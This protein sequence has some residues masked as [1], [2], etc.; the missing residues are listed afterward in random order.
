MVHVHSSWGPQRTFNS[1]LSRASG[2]EI[3][4]FRFYRVHGEWSDLSPT[5]SD[6]DTRQGR[7]VT[8]ETVPL[9]GPKEAAPEEPDGVGGTVLVRLRRCVSP[10]RRH[11]SGTRHWGERHCD[12]FWS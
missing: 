3:G 2:V 12:P 11:T 1:P 7:W 10:S 4:L 9:K 6:T 5:L 8:Y